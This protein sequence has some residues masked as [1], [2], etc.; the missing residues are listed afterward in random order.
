MYIDPWW[1]TSVEHIWKETIQPRG[2]PI[3]WTCAISIA[4]YLWWLSRNNNQSAHLISKSTPNRILLDDLAKALK[5]QKDVQP[6][7]NA[8]CSSLAP[9]SGRQKTVTPRLKTQRSS[10]LCSSSLTSKPPGPPI[11]ARTATDE[12][13]GFACWC[14][15]E[16]SLFRVYIRGRVD[17]TPVIPPYN[18][19]SRRGKVDLYLQVTNATS[20]YLQVFW[21]N[22]KGAEAPEGKKMRLDMF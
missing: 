1:T 21:V 11:F 7:V 22:F 19:R 14:D 16:A 5:L 8:D 15:I 10:S 20:R 18:P 12:H 2:V 3:L 17:D 6:E 9:F 4:S 13:P